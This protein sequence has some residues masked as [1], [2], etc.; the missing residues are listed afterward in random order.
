[1]G[2]LFAVNIVCYLRMCYDINFPYFTAD[3]GFLF[4]TSFLEIIRIYLGR[5]GKGIIERKLQFYINKS[6]EYLLQVH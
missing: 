2:E 5:K 6:L 3:I 1:M 4:G